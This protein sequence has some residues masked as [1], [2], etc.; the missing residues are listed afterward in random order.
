[1]TQVAG[2]DLK[3]ERER[4]RKEIGGNE[5]TK[6]GL[7]SD[8]KLPLQGPEHSLNREPKYCLSFQQPSGKEDLDWPTRFKYAEVQGCRNQGSRL[9]AQ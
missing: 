1:M 7:P 6:C 4:E 9:G 2:A 5:A 8:T 3:R